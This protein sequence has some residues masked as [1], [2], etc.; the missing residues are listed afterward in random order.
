MTGQRVLIHSLFLLLLPIIVAWCGLS[1]FSAILLVIITLLWR[2]AISLSGI[3]FPAKVPELELETISASHFVEKVRWCMDRLGIEYKETPMAGVLGVFF[4]GRTVPRLKIRTGATRSQ[5]GDS[6]DILRYLW[7]RYATSEQA[8]FLR[9]TP[10]RLALE[11]RLDRYGVDLQVWVYYHVLSQRELC[12]HAWGVNNHA[13]PWWQRRALR[14][15]FPLMSLMIRN[16]FQITD[17]HYAKAVEHID[18][19]LADCEQK[20][21]DGRVSLLGEDTPNYTDFTFAAISA[22]WLQPKD[23]AAGKAEAVRIREADFTAAMAADRQRWMN[24]YPTALTFIETL[25]S[26]HRS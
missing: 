4:T 8:D 24:N 11:Q 10:E 20:L 5:I 18:K 9:P 2:W 21:A 1:T 22:L 7:G 26:E 16:A 23:F 14:I 17:R 15:F 12:L 3:L 19:L 6:P 25:Y 13:L